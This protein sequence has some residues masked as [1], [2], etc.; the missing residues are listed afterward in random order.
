MKRDPA[1]P[2][3]RRLTAGIVATLLGLPAA[4]W[5]AAVF[6]RAED[7]PPVAAPSA[8]TPA[9]PTQATAPQPVAERRRL[10]EQELE[11]IVR[12]IKLGEDRQADIRREISSLDKDRTRIS[13]QMIAATARAQGLET[14][15]AAAEARIET[16]EADADKVKE[17]N[18][19]L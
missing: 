17:S 5:P 3:A 11:T 18:K 6:A 7:R 10:T 8:S 12:D 16:I 14:S 4:G 15:L 19:A 9:P 1:A 2:A 13:E